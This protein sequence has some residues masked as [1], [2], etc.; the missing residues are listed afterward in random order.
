MHSDKLPTHRHQK[1]LH[2]LLLNKPYPVIDIL[3][4]KWSK[5]KYQLK[6]L[7]LKS[8][9]DLLNRINTTQGFNN[10]ILIFLNKLPEE[11]LQNS[12]EGQ[13]RETMRKCLHT[14]KVNPE[15]YLS[16]LG[17]E[18]QQSILDIMDLL[19]ETQWQYFLK[20]LG[21]KE[22]ILYHALDNKTHFLTL[23]ANQIQN[24]KDIEDIQLR[25]NLIILKLV[26]VF[27]MTTQ[28]LIQL[29][30][31]QQCLEYF[32]IDEIAEDLS[33]VYTYFYKDF[34]RLT[35]ILNYV[36]K[37]KDMSA[38]ITLQDILSK[39]SNLEVI[40]KYKLLSNYEETKNFIDN[41]YIWQNALT[42][43]SLKDYELET[44]CHYFIL[45]C[46]YDIIVTPSQEVCDEF[47]AQKLQTLNSLLRQMKNFVLLCQI[48]EDILKFT[49]LRWE[50]LQKCEE[51]AKKSNN[52]LMSSDTCY[53]DDDL[54]PDSS[55][56]S[57]TKTKSYHRTGFICKS[58]AFSQ[59]FNFLR[60]FVTKKLHS[61]DFKNACSDNQ[62][63]FQDIVDY[64]TD[65]LWK[66]S[67]LE[68]LEYSQNQ[69]KVSHVEIYLDPEYLPHFV[70]YHQD[71]LNRV[72]SDDE[73]KPTNN[74]HSHYTSLTRRKAAKKR[75]RATFSGSIARPKD[76]LSLQQCRV[77]A[78][79]LANSVA[80]IDP[81]K[82][83]DKSK[84]NL[85][86]TE[87][88]S[89]VLKLLESPQRL[90]VLALSLKSFNDAKQ[91]IEVILI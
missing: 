39:T 45:A 85:E 41:Y 36:E 16:L 42:N 75:R 46:V 35:V 63:R 79:A 78:N 31:V 17:S 65:I 11:I 91:I 51:G 81:L 64:I 58:K 6:P 2:D 7:L 52:L 29:P 9:E 1:Q 4:L 70:S 14:T 26:Q 84:G 22:Y 72:S 3:L 66:Y 24:F 44:V 13:L 38:S 25:N 18:S 12:L 43:N 61:A 88:R 49:Y 56:K 10:K 62:Q 5:F 77:R 27:S 76:D 55:S 21:S 54:M 48:L 50:H 71:A 69:A 19:K 30:N 34:K 53:T 59:L 73:D 90:A 33:P 28:F 67:L 68:K 82:H 40:N 80:N 74:Y 89:I 87:E 8:L 37:F 47:Y 83:L 23:M 86:A 57:K 15:F 32:V 20:P 60:T